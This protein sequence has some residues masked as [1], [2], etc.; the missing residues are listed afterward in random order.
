MNVQRSS[1]STL[2]RP[3]A[4][5]G[6]ETRLHGRWLVGVRGLCMLVAFIQVVLLL[7]NVPAPAF[8]GKT[9]VRRV[10]ADDHRS[11]GGKT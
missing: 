8:G 2:E 7:L 1:T 10:I 3:D 4:R 5:N 9:T 6:S 11:E